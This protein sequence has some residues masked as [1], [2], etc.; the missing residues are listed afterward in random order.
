MPCVMACGRGARQFVDLTGDIQTASLLL[1]YFSEAP[2]A[3]VSAGGSGGS[4]PVFAWELWLD[5]YRDMLDRWQMWEQRCILD[6]ALAS[7]LQVSS[8]AA[9]ALCSMP[10]TLERTR[11]RTR[12]RT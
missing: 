12:T 8:C 9:P 11:T 4:S 6:I 7:L 3:N 10:V 1:C 2:T 5:E